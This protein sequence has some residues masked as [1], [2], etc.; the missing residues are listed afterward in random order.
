[1]ADACRQN[2]VQLM[3]GVM[4]VH[5]ERT[6]AMKEKLRGRHPRTATPTRDGSV[7]LSIGTQFLS[8]TSER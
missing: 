7:L 3:D 6:T 2:G 1:M 5:H 8:E 4:W